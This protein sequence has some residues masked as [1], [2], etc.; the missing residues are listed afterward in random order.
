MN[1]LTIEQTNAALSFNCDV[2]DD[3]LE[4]A[5]GCMN[6]SPSLNCANTSIM[7]CPW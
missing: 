4:E 3:V 1:E 7:Q 6:A 2:S 5:G